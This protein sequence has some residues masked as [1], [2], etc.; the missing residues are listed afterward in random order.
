LQQIYSG[1]GVPNFIK[2]GQFLYDI[3]QKNI[4]VSFS[5][6][7]VDVVSIKRN[8]TVMIVNWISQ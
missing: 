5:G 8:M 6:H 3:L 1:N 2:I 7:S 4:L